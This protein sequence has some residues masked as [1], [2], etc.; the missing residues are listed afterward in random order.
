MLKA[1]V[2][3]ANA[4]V[5]VEGSDFPQV[6]PCLRRDFIYEQFGVVARV[7]NCCYVDKDSIEKAQECLK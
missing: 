2:R 6:V 5:E 4:Q 7:L 1:R 3:F